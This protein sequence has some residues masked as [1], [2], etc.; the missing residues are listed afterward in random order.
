[1]SLPHDTRAPHRQQRWIDAVNVGSDD[2]PAYGV[3]E[4]VETIQDDTFRTVVQVKRPT[5][6][7]LRNVMLNG[8]KIIAGLSGND[9]GSGVVT[10]DYPAY[11]LY[12][13]GTPE[14]GEIWGSTANSF[15][16]KPGASGFMIIGD[17]SG[18]IV[19]VV[20]QPAELMLAEAYLLAELCPTDEGGSG[21]GSEG[22]LVNVYGARL[23]P[24][25]DDFTPDRVV[26]DYNHA[27][28]AGSKVMMYRRFCPD[29]EEEWVIKEIELRPYCSVSGVEDRTSCVVGWGL[30]TM[31]E[32]C[33]SWVPDD[34]CIIYEKIDCDTTLPACDTTLVWDPLYACCLDDQ[35]GS[36]TGT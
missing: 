27:G 25:C 30:R 1:M 35:W 34:V 11:A 10:N 8:P 15:A 7:G 12:S 32:Y 19:R 2:I 13:G 20:R 29:G 18:G 28:P 3:V 26:N 21:T 33:D 22:Q 23:I 4:I 5:G 24:Y 6:N 16:L 31:S 9:A 17:A 36:S 14:V